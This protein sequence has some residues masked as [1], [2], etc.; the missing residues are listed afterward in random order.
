MNGVGT[1]AR[2]PAGRIGKWVTLVI[3]LGV[4]VALAPLGGKLSD[5]ED[6]QAQSWL[7][8]NAESTKVVQITDKFRSTN[9]IPAV[10]VY[11]KDAGLTAADLSAIDTDKRRLGTIE[12]VVGPQIAGPIVSGQQPPRAAQ[13][14]VPIDAGANGWSTLPGI[15]DQMRAMSHDGISVHVTG[16][17][18]TGADSAE[19][20]SGIDGTLLFAALGVVILMLLLTYRSP[21]LWLL[22]V[23]AAGSALM[24]AQGVIYLLAKYAHLTV[25]GQSAGILT[26][27]VF[28]AGTD[29]ALLLVARHRE[30]LRRH[31]DRHEAMSF[32]LHRAG[33]AIW[34][35]AAT[36]IVGMLCLLFADL[37]STA[38]LGPVAAIGI[39]IAL[40][41]M[42]TLLPALLAIF[43]RWVFWPVRPAFGSDSHVERTWWARIGGR[44]ARAPRLT[45]VVTAMVL[46]VLALGTL[47]L[48]A[49]GLTNAGS[50]TST[51]DSVVGE[52]ILAEHF[53]AGAGQPIQVV[54]NAGSAQAVHT[55]FAAVPGVTAVQQP[56]IRDGYAYLEGTT[57]APPDSSAGIA[58]LER[59]RDAVHAVPG[60]NALA[61]GQSAIVHDTETAN[62]HDRNLIIPI[63]LL[64]VFAILAL[65]LRAVI[66][67]LVLIATVV[68]SFFATMGISWFFFEHVFHF[69]GAD[70]SFPL[71]VFVFLVALG[72]DYNI[73]LMTRVHEEAKQHGT[74]RGALTGLAAT[75]GVIT[76]AGLVLAGTFAVL[77]A[78]PVTA[79]AEIGFAVAVGVLIDTILVHAG[80]RPL[81]V[82]AAP[83]VAQAGRGCRRAGDPTNAGVTYE[84][85]SG[86]ARDVLSGAA[87]TSPGSGDDRPAQ[88]RNGPGRS[89]GRQPDVHE[90]VE[91][92]QRQDQDDVAGGLQ[93]VRV[94]EP[95]RGR[96][97]RAGGH[98]ET[99]DGRVHGGQ[100]QGRHQQEQ[101]QAAPSDEEH[102]L[103]L[104][105]VGRRDAVPVVLQSQQQPGQ[106]EPEPGERAG[107]A[108][109]HGQPQHRGPYG[110]HGQVQARGEQ[111]DRHDRAQRGGGQEPDENH[112]ERQRT[113]R[114]DRQP[115][116]ERVAA[117]S[118]H[119]LGGL[120][121]GS[122]GDIVVAQCGGRVGD[123]DLV[124]LHL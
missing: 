42:V 68:L 117:G 112:A 89:H 90:G 109:D 31:A 71:F 16:P 122:C 92:Q 106:A 100:P 81:H 40:L 87:F 88:R 23:L 65:L 114:E 104:G 61:G 99:D 96:G 22:P 102:L 78:L 86:S 115:E 79:F 66:A 41:A 21:V 45:W 74:R 123:S 59:V 35:S 7:P 17:A 4:L 83:V 77:G 58:T 53:P 85:R 13:I 56:V 76:S 32:A 95:D 121:G 52:Q 34:A 37:N 28:G 44:I 9:L 60:A 103:H 43:G 107:D 64:V 27:L 3:W 49:D 1:L 6:N 118:H 97:D 11:T 55:S 36:V 29:Y 63:V 8:G 105:H 93:Q 72:I 15:V 82:V 54:A 38:G 51:P 73:F 69:Q 108:G 124:A 25:N 19:A 84:G 50:F 30:E 111:H 75:G 2:L 46:G 67:P 116:D 5:V 70:A 119:D 24:A 120:G 14:I 94:T 62:A 39:G 57:Q 47:N 10:I 110:D 33:P 101:E 18:G 20:F 80:C 48:K 98:H 26:V 12:G 113:H 91:A